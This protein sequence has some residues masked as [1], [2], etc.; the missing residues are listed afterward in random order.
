MQNST[1]FYLTLNKILKIHSQPD[2]PYLLTRYSRFNTKKF[3]YQ[4][5]ILLHVT[6]ME[7]LI[8]MKREIRLYDKYNIH[9]VCFI[10]LIK[11]FKN[12]KKE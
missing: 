6:I 2:L 1:F 10:L 9:I 3:T 12:F 5:Q 4:H 8:I 11:Q 7:Y